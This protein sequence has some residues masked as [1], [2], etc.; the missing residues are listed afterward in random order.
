MTPTS[1]LSP[2]GV[3]SRCLLFFHQFDFL[4]DLVSKTLEFRPGEEPRLFHG[5]ISYFID[6]KAEEKSAGTT[7]SRNPCSP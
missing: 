7:P 3:G 4:D 5:N 1:H 6:K 2:D